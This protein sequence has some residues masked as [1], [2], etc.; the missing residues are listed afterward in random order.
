MGAHGWVVGFCQP[1]VRSPSWSWLPIVEAPGCLGHPT[2]T[3]SVS[4]TKL[5]NYMNWSALYGFPQLRKTLSQQV[6]NNSH[7][8]GIRKEKW[9]LVPKKLY[10]CQAFLH[11]LVFLPAAWTTRPTVAVILLCLCFPL[12][13]GSAVINIF[14]KGINCI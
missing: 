13:S 7:D 4:A 6:K 12:L 2:S 14:S 11:L 3:D 10:H 5:F 9:N 1:S 8:T